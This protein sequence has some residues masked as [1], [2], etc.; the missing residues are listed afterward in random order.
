MGVLYRV[1]HKILPIEYYGI[2]TDFNRRIAEHKNSSSNKLLREFIKKYSPSEF[3]FERLVEEDNIDL[4]QELEELVIY[5]AK[6]LKCKLICNVLIGSVLQGSSSQVGENHWNARLSEKDI[7]DIREIY[8][9]GGITQKQIGEIYNISNKTVSK[10]TTGYRWKDISTEN[11]VKQLK[12]NKKA[13]RR[14]L[15]DAQ[16]IEI[17]NCALSTYK[18][19][20]TI[21]VPKLASFYGISKQSMRGLLKGIYYKNLPGPLLGIDYYIEYGRKYE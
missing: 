4:L 10:V 18:D 13:N 3:I 1:K 15:T 17:R 11:T 14:K 20:N 6:A 8:L 2:T 16:V 9:S 5:E 19:S 7:C 21:D 12:S